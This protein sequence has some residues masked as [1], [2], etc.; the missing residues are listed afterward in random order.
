MP[1]K[2]LSHRAVVT[3]LGAVTPIG[4]DHATFWRNLVA[5]TSGVGPITTFDPTGFDVRIAAEVKDFDPTTVMDRKMAR[6]MSRFVHL[7]MAAGSEAITDS[8]LDFS[9]WAPERR[10]RVAVAFNTGGGGIEQVTINHDMTLDGGVSDAKPFAGADG[11]SWTDSAGRVFV[12][13]LGELTEWLGSRAAAGR[14]VP[15]GFPRSGRF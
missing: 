5:G 2:D 10:D 12:K 14:M 1:D 8:G 11:L 4:N 9:D 6:R 15:K 3:G 7:G 13:P